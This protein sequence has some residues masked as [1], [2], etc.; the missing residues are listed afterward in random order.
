MKKTISLVVAMLVSNMAFA[1]CDF[2]RDVKELPNGDRQYTKECHVKVGETIQDNKIKD[3]QINKYVEAIKFK[4]LAITK[5][6][7]R[8]DKWMNT[9]LKLEDNIQKIDSYKNTNQWIYFGLGALTVFA[10]GMAAAQLSGR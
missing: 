1:D 5:S 6:D 2:A 3:E 8:G 10:A 9:S 4:D 7:E